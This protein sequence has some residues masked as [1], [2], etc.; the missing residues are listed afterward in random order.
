ML[1][2][3][4]GYHTYGHTHSRATD[5]DVKRIQE[6]VERVAATDGLRSETYPYVRSQGAYEPV[7]M[8][9]VRHLI[10]VLSGETHS[11]SAVLSG[12]RGSG[13]TEVVTDVLHACARYYP[14]RNV[15]L[16]WFPGM[17]AEVLRTLIISAYGVALDFER[18]NRQKT[19]VIIEDLPDLSLIPFITAGASGN[20][21]FIVTTSSPDS[22]AMP[23]DW[24]HLRL[25]PLKD[26]VQK[27]LFSSFGRGAH[28]NPKSVYKKYHRI[29]EDWCRGNVLRVVVLADTFIELLPDDEAW[30]YDR[31]TYPE[32]EIAIAQFFQ[33]L[34]EATV[35]AGTEPPAK[36]PR[37]D[38]EE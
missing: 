9:T 26:D 29:I 24:L 15:S 2:L 19:L 11:C 5:M 33:M 3:A 23:E 12:V 37:I 1:H 14:N 10:K 7:Y 25:E 21:R 4:T 8:D 13:K 22:G 28:F 20:V 18:V 17:T 16:A 36:L 6:L 38:A 34:K 30:D 31:N 32:V 35:N 27:A